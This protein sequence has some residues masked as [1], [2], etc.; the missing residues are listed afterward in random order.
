MI[1]KLILKALNLPTAISVRFSPAINRLRLRLSGVKT[2]ES[3]FLLG[4]PY[5]L[6]G[7]GKMAIG[8]DFYMTNGS[9]INP[10]GGND[11]GAFYTE[12]GATIIIG[13]HV[14][15]SG[16][17]MWIAKSLTIGNNVNIGAGVLIMDTDCHQMDYRMRRHDAVEHFSRDVLHKAV[18]SEPI[19]IEDDVWIGAGAMVLKGV[20]IGARSIIGAG[21]VVTKSIPVDCVAAGNPAKVIKHLN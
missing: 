1:R 8:K 16:T 21:S 15:M 4:W 5:L 7:G 12:P 3:V 20:T 2:G 19:I 14:G 17:R 10:L 11:R 18:Q 13:D 9:G 6:V